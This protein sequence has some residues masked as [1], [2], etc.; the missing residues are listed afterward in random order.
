MYIQELF[1]ERDPAVMHALIAA[2]PL[3]MWVTEFD[4]QLVVNHIPFIV[5]STRGSFGT[6][7]GHV[8]RANT[9][10]R[11]LSTRL[12][13]VVVFQGPQTYITPSWYP[14]K[15]EHG[16]V[17][18]TWNYAVVHAHGTPRVIE[19]PKWLRAHVT[20]L[21]TIHEAQR[22]TPWH[23]SDA[24]ERFIDTLLSGIV[25]IE[26]PI[27]RLVG[28]WKMSQNRSPED[29]SGVIA[30]LAKSGRP[31]E[32]QVARLVDERRDQLASHE[33]DRT[34]SPRTRTN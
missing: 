24:P 25:G 1:E 18:P 34:T 23:V 9:V 17:V 30:G 10:W 33:T 8:A 20:S 5:D 32:E 4:G 26:I 7:V 29:R 3:G 31:D 2:N 16:K 22:E 11:E 6:L 27:A 21:T 14:G 19:D 13:S 12:E 28:K 15:L